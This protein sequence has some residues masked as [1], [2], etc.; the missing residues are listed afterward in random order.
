[1][2]RK[3]IRQRREKTRTLGFLPARRNDAEACRNKTRSCRVRNRRAT[4]DA[5]ARARRPPRVSR[6]LDG[7]V[8]AVDRARD[9]ATRARASV[10]IN[11]IR[12]GPIEIVARRSRCNFLRFACTYRRCWWW[13]PRCW[14]SHRTRRGRASR[15]AR[16]RRPEIGRGIEGR[17][18]SG[19]VRTSSDRAMGDF[20]CRSRDAEGFFPVTTSSVVVRTRARDARRRRG[21]RARSP[22]DALSSCRP[23][24]G[25][26]VDCR[27]GTYGEGGEGRAAGGLLG[28]GEGHHGRALGRRGGDRAGAEGLGLA[29]E[30][31]AGH[32]GGSSG[33]DGSHCIDSVCANMTGVRAGSTG[34]L[35][36][37]EPTQARKYM[38]WNHLIG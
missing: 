4:G 1:M 30:G 34:K 24:A 27:A 6:V 14:R 10:Q 9:D 7:D 37:R 31:R 11:S 23:G 19:G 22:R 5:S 17:A 28:R 38:I 29:D 16:H 32:D 12:R 26:E 2:K 36:N 33:G 25:R 20:A 13:N 15:R 18:V 8:T 3:R 21:R 35:G